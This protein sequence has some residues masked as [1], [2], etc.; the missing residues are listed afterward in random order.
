VIYGS[1]LLIL[2]AVVMFGLGLVQGSNAFLVGSIAASLFAAIL[3]VL[4]ARQAAAARASFGR[5]APAAEGLGTEA[6]EPGP[7]L[8]LAD[9]VVVNKSD[10]QRAKTAHT[11]IEQRLDQNRRKQRLVDT[12]AKRHRDSGVDRLF[13]LIS[14]SGKSKTAK[15]RRKK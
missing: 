7:V 4:A 10:L 5:R 14:A 2:V 15:E 12:V 6:A 9:V 3:V 13:D 1:L 8:D 11:E